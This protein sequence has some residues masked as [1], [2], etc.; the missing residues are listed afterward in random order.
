[1]LVTIEM[2]VEMVASECVRSAMGEG[3][4]PVSAGAQ[5]LQPAF[6]KQGREVS[7]L[8]GKW[9]SSGCINASKRR[10]ATMYCNVGAL[11]SGLQDI[12]VMII[13]VVRCLVIF[14]DAVV[15]N[16]HGVFSN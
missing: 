2:T 11:K 12:P 5:C 10:L 16:L 13:L 8:C 7:V 3:S 6:D 4:F 14:K 9:K 1:M 15:Q